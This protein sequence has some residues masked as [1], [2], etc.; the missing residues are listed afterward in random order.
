MGRKEVHPYAYVGAAAALV[1]HGSRTRLYGLRS[2]LRRL[3]LTRFVAAGAMLGLGAMTFPL[4]IF[5]P[6]CFIQSL[7]IWHGFHHRGDVP[8]VREVSR[9]GCMP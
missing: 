7:Q 1:P 8:P 3:A 4:T 9:S 5:A 6:T 2:T